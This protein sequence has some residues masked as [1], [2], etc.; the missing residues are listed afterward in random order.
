[1]VPFSGSQ[2]QTVEQALWKDEKLSESED[3]AQLSE[4]SMCLP[5]H[6]RFLV[7]PSWLINST[8]FERL[9]SGLF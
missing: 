1:M 7:S 9:S 8:S 5:K 2:E 3:A 4:L 6:T